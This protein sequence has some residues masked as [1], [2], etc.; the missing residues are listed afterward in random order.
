MNPRPRLTELILEI[1][2]ACHHRCIHCST[3]GGLPI[4][5][6]LTQA[7]RLRVLREACELGLVELRLLGGDPLFRWRDTLELLKEANHRGVQEGLLYTSAVESQLEW[8]DTLRGL[9][10][11][12]L[13]AEASIY[14]A[15]SEMHDAITLRVGSLERLLS[16]SR[17]A[18]RVGFDLNWNFVWMK[19]NFSELESVVSLARTMG[20]KRVRILRLMLNGRARDNRA[21]LELSA[22][23][24]GQCD[25]IVQSLSLRYPEV[26][27]A[28]SKPL[29][30]RLSEN[31]R[32]AVA[33]CSAGDAQ[34]VVQADG[35][36]LPCIGLKDM[37]Q[38]RIGNVRSE[39]LEEMYLR[40]RGPTFARTSQ[41]FHEC[42]AI[43]FQKRPE[44]IQLTMGRI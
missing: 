40:S 26:L 15:A 29:A 2:N 16:N 39:S 33:S 28:S 23:W 14:S 4:A 21:L 38:F 31:N 41:E 9:A 32:S 19:P 36:V 42:P 22:E 30:Y 34:L 7:E 5:N 20:I 8:I 25:S 37:P 3:V 44:L 27:I 1:T 18:V 6:E 24:E 13:S 12:H 35:E 10:P 43:L 11:I 17:E